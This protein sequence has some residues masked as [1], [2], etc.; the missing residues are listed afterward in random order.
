[1]TDDQYLDKWIAA[2]RQAKEN[3]KAVAER[4][5]SGDGAASNGMHHY[6][7]EIIDHILAEVAE[8]KLSKR[9][10]ETINVLQKK[11]EV[12]QQ[13][14]NGYNEEFRKY[15]QSVEIE[16]DR[17]ILLARVFF[18]RYA[19]TGSTSYLSTSLKIVDYVLGSP[20]LQL[21]EDSANHFVKVIEDQLSAIKALQTR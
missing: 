14:L 13:V 12:F 17:Y 9:N 5:S 18:D 3:V 19:Q 7:P 4:K 11:F 20:D 15:D 2:R 16:T 10:A 6:V 8:K 21:R 1:M